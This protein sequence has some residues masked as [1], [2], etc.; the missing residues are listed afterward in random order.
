ML[1]GIGEA[2]STPSL[3]W[4]LSSCFLVGRYVI[5]RLA[6]FP[7]TPTVCTGKLEVAFWPFASFRSNAVLRSLSGRSGHANL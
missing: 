4:A 7:F 6:A 3:V 2:G 1:F 5:R